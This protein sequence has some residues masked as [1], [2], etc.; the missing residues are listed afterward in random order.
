MSINYLNINGET[1]PPDSLDGT[2]LDEYSNNDILKCILDII[3]PGKYY[4][5]LRAHNLSL[6]TS[7]VDVYIL[8]GTMMSG[9]NIPTP[10]LRSGQNALLK[11]CSYFVGARG[12]VTAIKAGKIT[13][14][15]SSSVD[16][17]VVYIADHNLDIK[18]KDT[19]K[20]THVIPKAHGG[21]EPKIALTTN[22]ITLYTTAGQGPYQWTIAEPKNYGHLIS[23]L[24]IETVNNDNSLTLSA[25]FDGD[26]WPCGYAL[27]KDEMVVTLTDATGETAQ[28][29]IELLIQTI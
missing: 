14:Q 3:S 12:V 8:H 6:N 26:N 1:V 18:C 5:I 15:S 10:R 20:L 2:L 21:C 19:L 9:E 17:L 13:S 22:S 29:N 28:K 11:D 27:Y 7:D 4:N 16:Y 23:N 25:T 24:K